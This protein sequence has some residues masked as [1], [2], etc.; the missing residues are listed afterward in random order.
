MQLKLQVWH[1]VYLILLLAYVSISYEHLDPDIFSFVSE[2]L[3][4]SQLDLCLVFNSAIQTHS[5]LWA[6]PF[7][8]SFGNTQKVFV[9]LEV[10]NLPCLFP[11]ET[12]FLLGLT[13]I[14][15]YP[16]CPQPWTVSQSLLMRS[17]ITGCYHINT[18]L[19]GWS[20]KYHE[21]W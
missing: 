1:T 11:I 3:L 6:E 12:G 14:R 5:D 4:K 18:S 9:L 13:C 16:P 15:L 10:K 21:Q 8:C 2:N 19:W 20:S 7:Q 17:T